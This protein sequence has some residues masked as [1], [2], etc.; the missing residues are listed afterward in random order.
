M[1]NESSSFKIN[2]FK[3]TLKDSDVLIDEIGEES[4]SRSTATIEWYAEADATS[5]GIN[6]IRPIVT[7]VEIEYE[8][9]EWEGQPEDVG[10]FTYVIDDLDYI[11][12]DV[13]INECV[14]PLYP[15]D[16]VFNTKDNNV[17]ITF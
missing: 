4:T 11:D 15:K 13:D 5:E 8:L 12:V 9:E 16:V 7:K 1:I 2:D 10:P 17:S 6:S 14:L 3:T